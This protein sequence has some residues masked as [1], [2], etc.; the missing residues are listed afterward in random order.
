MNE[1]L[2]QIISRNFNLIMY[3]AM[4]M[5]VILTTGLYICI[6]FTNYTKV[7]NADGETIP[8]RHPLFVVNAGIII[9]FIVVSAVVQPY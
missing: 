8:F 5:F 9:E 2:R 6:T 3:L 7:E 1:A 4:A